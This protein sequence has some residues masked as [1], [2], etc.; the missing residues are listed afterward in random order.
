MLK[1]KTV[2]AVAFSLMLATGI[3]AS[4]IQANKTATTEKAPAK[5]AQAA[6]KEKTAKPAAATTAKS[7]PATKEATSSTES[8]PSTKHHKKHHRRHHKAATTE[9]K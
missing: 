3:F 1:R 7:A 6:P 5:T 2:A 9:S 4:P 8:T